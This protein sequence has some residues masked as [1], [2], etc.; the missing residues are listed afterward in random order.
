MAGQESQALLEKG[1]KKV[2][3]NMSVA[4]ERLRQE[5]GVQRR[6]GPFFASRDDLKEHQT[7]NVVASGFGGHADIDSP[8]DQFVD[9]P[10]GDEVTPCA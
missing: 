1:R 5:L 7:R 6:L 9:I 10:V 3:R 8:G 4:A 2:G